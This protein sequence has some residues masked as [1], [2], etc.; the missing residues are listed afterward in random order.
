MYTDIGPLRLQTFTLALALAII[1]SMGISITRRPNKRS[2]VAD[3]CIGALIMGL[4]FARAGHV[5]LN[6]EH[7]A[8]NTNQI[9]RL[10]LKAADN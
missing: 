5:L 3:A 1:T 6:W 8:F 7:F 2:A 4:I 9:L 10:L